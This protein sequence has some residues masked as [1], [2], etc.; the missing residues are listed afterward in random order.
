MTVYLHYSP[1][2]F[3]N[4]IMVTSFVLLGS[5]LWTNTNSRYMF[6]HRQRDWH[7]NW[8][9]HMCHDQW[10]K[11]AK[12]MVSYKYFFS[13]S[14]AIF[15]VEQ[16]QEM[17]CKWQ[18]Y[19]YWIIGMLHIS[20]YLINRSR[21]QNIFLRWQWFFL[22]P[23]IGWIAAVPKFESCQLCSG[24]HTVQGFRL[25]QCTSVLPLEKCKMSIWELVCL[26]FLSSNLKLRQHSSR[27]CKELK[28]TRRSSNSNILNFL[29][30][31]NPEFSIKYTP[32]F[33]FCFNKGI[34][35]WKSSK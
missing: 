2:P 13:S 15:W 4:A 23:M 11:T 21:R 8:H 22:I 29:R 10:K 7:W 30:R 35:N 28:I 12:N 20:N 24:I 25:D 32:A 34:E 19:W 18:N 14:T 33:S 27:S 16:V 1:G 17:F 5:L 9:R 26:H 31:C 3:C 6:K